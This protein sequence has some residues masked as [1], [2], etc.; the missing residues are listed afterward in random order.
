MPTAERRAGRVHAGRGRQ[1]R[2]QQVAD[3]G[4]ARS[5]LNARAASAAAVRKA[6]TAKRMT[7]APA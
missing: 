7:K 3:H 4:P 2:E 1:Q 5:L 6:Y